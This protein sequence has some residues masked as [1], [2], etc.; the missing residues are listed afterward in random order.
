VPLLLLAAAIGVG[1]DPVA[2]RLTRRLESLER[3][4]AALGAGNFHAR[5]PV[6]GQDEVARLA[7]RFNQSAEHIEELM[8]ANRD[9]LANASH[10][11]RSPLARLSMATDLLTRFA[12]R[13]SASSSASTVTGGDGAFD[14]DA[15]RTEIKRSVAEL[16][17]LIDEILLAS[18]IEAGSAPMSRAV[19]DLRALTAEILDD[20]VGLSAVQANAD[21]A[22]APE[23]LVEA[24]WRLLRRLLRN[25]V[26]NAQRHGGGPAEIELGRAPDGMVRLQVHDRGPGVPPAERERIFEPFY[27]ARG[28]S[29]TAGGVGLG[30][31]LVQRIARLHGGSARCEARAGGG[32]SFIV[33]LP[34]CGG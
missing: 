3:G 31:S 16:D 19:F 26:E 4:V 25:L 10:E 7:T 32:S 28:A 9:L 12:A 22:P 14:A 18:R 27:R 1:A 21:G 34:A 5:V 29:E 24:D 15:A 8:R 23:L 30:L 20:P 13:T 17:E 33:Q 11:L 6:D 2:R